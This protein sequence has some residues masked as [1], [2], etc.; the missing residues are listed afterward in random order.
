MAD[1]E[2]R[3]EDVDDDGD[4]EVVV[5]NPWLRT[6]LRFPEKLGD[7]FYGRR[8]TRGG[9]LQSLIY[10]PTGREHFMTS[11]ID[12][13]GVCP[14]GLPDELFAF[15]PMASDDGVERQFKMGVGVFTTEGDETV[16]EPLPWS[17]HEERQGEE[18]AVIFRQEAENLGGYSFVYEKRY[19]F[20]PDAAWFAM[21]VVWEN[22]GD[23]TLASD[24]DIHSFHV[25]GAPPHSSWHLAPKRAWV[26]YGKT[27]VRTVLKE[28]GP[29]FATPD[30]TKM[31]GARITWDLDESGWW[32]ALGPGNGDEF[33]LLRSRL[34]P[35]RG[36]AWHAWGAFTPQGICHVEVPPG[37]KTT[38][39]FDVTLGAR[40]KHFVTAGEDCGPHGQPR[41][42][43][44]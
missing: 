11:M 21:D 39:G 1:V 44:A 34:E 6:V 26:S 19:R 22:G 43:E 3:F 30:I 24:W 15:F 36:I 40:G 29:I 7:T 12:P 5:E 2:V 38:W 27:R 31:I 33:Y 32:Y 18:T 28:A 25:S 35:K 13:E 42:R 16:V 20:R 37:E 41:L 10:K 9:W 8:W 23:E 17:W 14:F 4:R